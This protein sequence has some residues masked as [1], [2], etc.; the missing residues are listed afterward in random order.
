MGT[1]CILVEGSPGKGMVMLVVSSVVA[2]GSGSDFDGCAD[3]LGGPI[4]SSPPLSSNV[5]F[6]SMATRSASIGETF[7]DMDKLQQHSQTIILPYCFVCAMIF[8]MVSQTIS[9]LFCQ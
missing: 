4:F 8:R 7:F 3:D 5:E 2:G 9:C 6:D 1:V